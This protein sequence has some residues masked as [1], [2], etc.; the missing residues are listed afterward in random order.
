M[1]RLEYLPSM[2]ELRVLKTD[3]TH[4]RSQ[5]FISS[6]S[7]PSPHDPISLHIPP[8]DDGVNQMGM[9]PQVCS[10]G[11]TLLRDFNCTLEP[12]RTI[13]TINA[14]LNE[15]LYEDAI[16]SY[17]LLVRCSAR[18]D[19]DGLGHKST[20]LCTAFRGR[21][22]AGAL[23]GIVQPYRHRYSNQVAFDTENA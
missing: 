9:L 18:V 8:I 20:A 6:I 17:L 23:I 12:L 1:S 4:L 10:V 11:S 14:D 5:S 2:L 15:T 21:R 19:R 16:V 13:T 22:L 3:Q 7:I